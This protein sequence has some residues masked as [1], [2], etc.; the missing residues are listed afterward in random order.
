MALGARILW[1]VPAPGHGQLEAIVAGVHDALYRSIAR[2][3][4]A[5]SPND[6]RYRVRLL[7]EQNLAWQE[8][9]A[10][11]KNGQWDPALY[12]AAWERL[13]G[14]FR[15]E[16]GPKCF[17]IACPNV[18]TEGYDPAMLL[19]RASM[20]DCLAQDFYLQKAYNKPGAFEH[21]RAHPRGLQWAADLAQKQGKLYGLSELGMDDD[22][23]AADARAT[24][25]WFRGLG[26]PLGHH[27]CW[28]DR[29]EVIDSCVTLG[30]LPGIGSEVVTLR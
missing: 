14:I 24:F 18:R 3:I 8:N 7:W 25:D 23:F 13:A 22:M 26:D 30:R 29:P 20:Y 9:A 15:A 12:V 2:Q 19:P 21:F 16:M 27:L 10:K 4:V 1:S 17:L 5:A 6:N 28:W 11:D